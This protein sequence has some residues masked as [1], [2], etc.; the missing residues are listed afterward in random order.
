MMMSAE[1][2]E[3]DNDDDGARGVDREAQEQSRYR[4]PRTR[5]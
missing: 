3:D 5:Y 1:G 2:E 4:K